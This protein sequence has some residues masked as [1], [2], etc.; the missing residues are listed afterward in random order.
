M[1]VLSDGL[2]VIVTLIIMTIT[3]TKEFVWPNILCRTI[4]KA[5]AHILTWAP[6]HTN[7]LYAIYNPNKRIMNRT[8]SRGKQ[9]HGG[10]GGGGAG[11]SEKTMVFWGW[12]CRSPESF[13][14]RWRGRPFHVE[15]MKME[16]AQVS[17]VESLVLDNFL[18]VMAASFV[19]CLPGSGCGEGWVVS[20]SCWFLTSAGTDME[21]RF[22]RDVHDMLLSGDIH[23]MLLS[24]DIH[25]LLVGRYIHDMLLSRY[26]HD[27]LV[28]GDIHDQLLSRD[29]HDMLM[30]K[31]I[32]DVL[33]SRDIHDMLV[34]TDI[35][36]ML[37]GRY[38]HDM[39]VSGDIHDM[40]VSGDIHDML[41]NGDINDM[42]VSGDIH[43]MLVS[44]DLMICWWAKIFM[45]CWW[46]EIFMRC[47]WAEIFMTCWW[48]DFMT[49]W[50][51]EISWHAGEQRYSWHA[52]EQRFHA[53]FCCYSGCRRR[54][55]RQGDEWTR[56]HSHADWHKNYTQRPLWHTQEAWGR[57]TLPHPSRRQENVMV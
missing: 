44:G 18:Q 48:A 56:W 10:G 21:N 36:D 42:L 38:I 22:S 31:D 51:A 50:W 47:W 16:K 53:L 13:F 43:D 35:H 40:L 25:G 9:Q 41:V 19:R 39:L 1:I 45:T 15:R 57:R 12:I 20:I 29:I 14:H 23:D 27:M 28:S 33:V 54:G 5:L 32:H 30:S 55:G 17:T 26:I 37:V 11:R 4:L 8:Y 3:V 46:V 6:T 52:G 34:S 49:C 24:G 2:Q 7:T